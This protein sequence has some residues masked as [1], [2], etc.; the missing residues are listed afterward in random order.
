MSIQPKQL[1]AVGEH[2]LE[3]AVLAVLLEARRK[4]TCIGAGEISKRAGI[5]RESRLAKKGGNDDITSGILGKLLKHG[6]VCRCPKKPDKPDKKDGW[7]LTD[8]EFARR[9]A[10]K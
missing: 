7:K 6:R 5:F 9:R 10:D 3:E 1:A 8:S 4:D 2:L